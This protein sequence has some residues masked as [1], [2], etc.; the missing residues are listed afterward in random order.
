VILPFILR[1]VPRRNLNPAPSLSVLLHP[2]RPSSRAGKETATVQLLWTVLYTLYVGARQSL[3]Q[4]ELHIT[5]LPAPSSLLLSSL[6]RH[7]LVTGPEASEISL[8]GLKESN[9]H[10]TSLS[11]A[12]LLEARH[13]ARCF[14][15]S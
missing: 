7:V 6:W 12:Q 1:Y 9:H 11:T 14:V 2:R 4:L 13:A 5:T 15:D 8:T 3:P 10:F